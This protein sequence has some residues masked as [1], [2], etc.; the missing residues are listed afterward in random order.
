MGMKSSLSN[1]GVLFCLACLAS[2][3]YKYGVGMG[4]AYFFDW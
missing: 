1:V 3:F 4:L 2:Q